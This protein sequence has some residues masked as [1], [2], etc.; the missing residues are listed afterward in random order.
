[1]LGEVSE[2]FQFLNAFQDHF[3]SQGCF[4]T[5]TLI[6]DTLLVLQ[7]DNEFQ[8]EVSVDERSEGLIVIRTGQQSKTKK[9]QGIARKV[10]L[11][12]KGEV[13]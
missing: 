6:E 5:N 12:Y 7:H 13:H 1:M 4:D 9:C 2:S 3:M 10:I 11:K 8:F